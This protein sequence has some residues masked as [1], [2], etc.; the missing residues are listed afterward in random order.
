VSF[1]II[2]LVISWGLGF[3]PGAVYQRGQDLLAPLAF[4][5]AC[6][7]ALAGILIS[8]LSNTAFA[9]ISLQTSLVWWVAALTLILVDRMWKK[10]SVDHPAVCIPSSITA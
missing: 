4:I 7:P 2:T 8:A 9:F 3:T 6:G 5:A 1:F 10:L